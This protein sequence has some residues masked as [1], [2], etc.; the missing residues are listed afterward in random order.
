MAIEI[1]VPTP[2]IRNLMREDKVHQ[3]YSQMQIGQKEHGMTTL[4]QS[5]LD[6]YMRRQISL[7]DAMGRCSNVEE[8][9]NMISSAR[10]EGVSGGGGRRR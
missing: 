3:I 2:A 10:G 8:F 1:M 7:E 9:R 5:L 4:N 6:L